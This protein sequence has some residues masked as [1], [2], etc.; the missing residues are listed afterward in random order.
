MR[1]A[2]EVR[3]RLK[4]LIKDDARYAEVRFLGSFANN[5][6]NIYVDAKG[7]E[8]ESLEELQ[9]MVESEVPDKFNILYWDESEKGGVKREKIKDG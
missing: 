1:Q 8:G 4:E 3:E 5:G 2:G 9:R 6:L 7:V